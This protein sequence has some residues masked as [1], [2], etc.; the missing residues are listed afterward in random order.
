MFGKTNIEAEY[1]SV[2]D[3]VE[4]YITKT[5]RVVFTGGEPTLFL[6]EISQ[7]WNYIKQ[8]LIYLDKVIFETNGTKLV[9]LSKFIDIELEDIKHIT[10]INWSPKFYNNTLTEYNIKLIYNHQN[11]ISNPNLFLKIV[12]VNSKEEIERIKM[13]LD[14]LK[15]N[16]GYSV[17]RKTYLLPETDKNGQIVVDKNLVVSLAQEYSINIS[18]R[19]Q[20]FFEIK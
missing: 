19:I 11:I 3:I 15:F 20:F 5:R 9:N 7:I 10:Y 1:I 12:I 16:F 17:L 18:P 4:T 8:N 14:N 6:K 13:F 2:K